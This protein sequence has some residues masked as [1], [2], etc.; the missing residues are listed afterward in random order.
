MGARDLV[1]PVRLSYRPDLDAPTLYRF[2]ASKALVRG[3]RGPVGAGKSVA[4]CW[5]LYDAGRYQAPITVGK[6][7]IRR[8]RSGVVRN[9]YA[10]LK[11]TTIK[12]WM[13]WFGPWT[14]IVYDSPIRGLLRQ[15]LEDG[16]VYEH[17]LLFVS[18]D[19][20]K[21][22]RKL[23]SLELTFLW[24]NEASELSKEIVDMGV[25][26]IWR[27]PSMKDGAGPTSS[28]VIMDTNAPGV[29]HWYYKL[30][31]ERDEGVMADIQV[32]LKPILEKRGR[33]DAPLMEFFAQPPAIIEQDGKYVPNPEAENVRH[34]ALGHGYW[35]QQVPGKRK[36]WIKVF[37][38]GQY[39]SIASG[40]VCYPEYDD[41]QH[42]AKEDLVADPKLPLRLGV[43]AGL[44]PACVITQ[45][46]AKGQ[47]RVLDEIIGTSIGMRRFA[48][49]FMRPFLQQHYR[50]FAMILHVDPAG[51]AR[52]Q[53]IESTVQRELADAGFP[54]EPAWTNEFLARR[55]A[56]AGFLTRMISGVG[57]AMAVSPRCK[58]LRTGFMSGYQIERLQVVTKS[59]EE[60]RYRDHPVKN[61]Y[62][63]IHEALQYAVMDY[64]EDYQRAAR[65]AAPRRAPA[66]ASV[67]TSRG[68]SIGY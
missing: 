50:G 58:T 23:K 45:I 1:E 35:L 24:F 52:D 13:D 61:S 65:Q 31:E 6:K 12:T 47:L 55:E 28:F 17:E 10:E 33:K 3:I 44:T 22:V 43:D 30:A 18:A 40:R 14:H 62:S 56:V 64:D 53:T 66:P 26:R 7:R 60:E 67:T 59:D 4:C 49:E 32:A 5:D 39:A 16:T 25:A 57:P 38:Q 20:P 19:R 11:T 42:C 27:Y 54:V 36:E 9:T 15:T 51:T 46:T 34:H 63:H 21:D 2:H 37:L 41:D 48:A 29:D 68:D 8:V